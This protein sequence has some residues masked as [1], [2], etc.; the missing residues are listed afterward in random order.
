MWSTFGL[1]LTFLTI[2]P[3]P[4]QRSVTASQLAAAMAWYPVV[5]LLLGGWLALVAWGASRL[6]P[7]AVVAVLLVI[8]LT[9]STRALHLDGLAD[10]LDGLGGGQTPEASLRIMKDH[11]VGTFGAV[12]LI[13]T[14]GAKT[15]FLHLCLAG[16]SWPDLLLFPACSRWAMV[17]LAY[18]APYARKEGG[19]GQPMATLTGG[20]TLFTATASTLLAAGLLGRLPGLLTLAVIAVLTGLLA[21]YFRRRLGGVTG[22]VFGA[23]NEIMELV[24][25]ACL[26]AL[27]AP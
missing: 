15:V 3:W 23:L 22:D 6:W 12:G 7:P 5:G 20:R 17:W 27:A 16:N 26:T 19:L 24:A 2:C 10:T 21:R 1:A 25:L 11:A 9:I 8:V 4:G 14:L 13:L 18:L